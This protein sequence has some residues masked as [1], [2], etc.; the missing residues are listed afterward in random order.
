VAKWDGYRTVGGVDDWPW[1]DCEYVLVDVEAVLKAPDYLHTAGVEEWRWRSALGQ[2][3]TVGE[4]RVARVEAW[5]EEIGRTFAE[6]LDGAGAMIEASAA[7]SSPIAV[8]SPSPVECNIQLCGIN[9][10]RG[11]SEGK[12]KVEEGLFWVGPGVSIYVTQCK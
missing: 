2:G 8:S 10:Q 7:R 4:E 1:V 11:M 3:P 12:Q 9:M 5:H 6:T